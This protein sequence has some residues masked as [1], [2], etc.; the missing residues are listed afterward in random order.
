MWLI[1]DHSYDI[2]IT[3]HLVN[4]AWHKGWRHLSLPFNQLKYKHYIKV[5]PH[6][7]HLCCGLYLLKTSTETTT[8]QMQR[9][10]TQNANA[11]LTSIMCQNAQ[12]FIWPHCKWQWCHLSSV[13]VKILGRQ[14]L[15]EKVMFSMA[16]GPLSIQAIHPVYAKVSVPRAILFSSSINVVQIQIRGFWVPKPWSEYEACHSRSLWNNFDHLELF[17]RAPESK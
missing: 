17:N 11:M 16:S 6:I 4:W 3:L 9:S 10:K 8:K 13:D 15:L 2:E 14:T 12:S 5:V 1:I 7:F